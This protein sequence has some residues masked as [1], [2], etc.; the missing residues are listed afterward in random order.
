MN[1]HLWN[2]NSKIRI[3]HSSA[4]SAVYFTLKVKVVEEIMS[5]NIV[6]FR[7]F[8]NWLSK[9]SYVQYIVVN[10]L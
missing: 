9:V 6:K 1:L 4:K 8:S 3:S 7:L 5:L 10:V 2:V